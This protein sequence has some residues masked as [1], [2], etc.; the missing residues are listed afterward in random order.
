MEY[1]MVLSWFTG[2]TNRANP[3]NGFWVFGLLAFWGLRLLDRGIRDDIYDW[4][5]ERNAPRWAYIVFGSLCQA[6]LIA[7]LVFLHNLGWF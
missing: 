6:P 3:V 2:G 1:P 4:I 7:Y 5:G